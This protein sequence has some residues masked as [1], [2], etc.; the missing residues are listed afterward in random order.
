MNESAVTFRSGELTLAGRLARPDGAGAFPGAVI[1]H[2][3]PMYGG[4][5]ENN[6]VEAIVSAMWRCGYATLRFNFR[7]VG[8]SEGEYDGGAGEADDARAAVE[9]LC[10]QEAVARAAIALAGYSFGAGIAMRAGLADLRVARVIAVALPVAAMD[11]G[12]DAQATKPVLLVS[13]DRDSY[14]PIA[15]L[16]QTARTLGAAA[17]LKVIAGADHFFGGCEAALDDAIARSIQGD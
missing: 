5:M 11:S 16:E 6:V 10:R 4:S 14:S 17:T 8:A 13:G 12:G 3:H 1:C 2:P 7:G 15:T 9:F